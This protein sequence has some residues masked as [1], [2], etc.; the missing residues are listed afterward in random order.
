MKTLETIK[1]ISYEISCPAEGGDY[2][3]QGSCNTCRYNVKYK[4]RDYVLCD[5]DDR[6]TEFKKKIGCSDERKM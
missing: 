3:N 6:V 1:K 2:I 4:A 5:Y